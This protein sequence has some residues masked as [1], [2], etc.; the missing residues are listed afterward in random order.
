M[1]IKKV[2]FA[3]IRSRFGGEVTNIEDMLRYD[4]AF[5][6]KTERGLI[7]FPIF[8]TPSGAAGGQITLARWDSFGL[9]A[10]PL[11]RQDNLTLQN[12]MNV[13]DWTTYQHP[14]I[15]G[16]T[17]YNRLVRVPLARYLTAKRLEDAARE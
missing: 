4:L 14:R 2:V 5:Q 9:K 16:P 12:S 13:D 6:H 15:T 17:D 3:R 8:Q 1:K 11:S 10:T 7:A